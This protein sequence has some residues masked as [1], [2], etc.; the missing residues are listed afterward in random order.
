MFKIYIQICMIFAVVI[1]WQDKIIQRITFWET[2]QWRYKISI[3]ISSYCVCRNIRCCD[4]I[5]CIPTIYN[6]FIFNF[7]NKGMQQH[8]VD[9]SSNHSSRSMS[10]MMKVK[11]KL[12]ASW[13]SRLKKIQS[14]ALMMQKAS[15][16]KICDAVEPRFKYEF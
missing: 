5:C 4:I 6:L 3:H 10:L 12:P 11:W 14:S 9:C 2:L 15:Y 1:I 16:Q 13:A 7:K 8:G